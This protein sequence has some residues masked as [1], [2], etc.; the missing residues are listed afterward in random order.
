VCVLHTWE[1]VKS[2]SM[3]ASIQCVEFSA[4]YIIRQE[5]RASWQPLEFGK[6]L[7]PL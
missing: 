6:L 3:Q 2:E 4:T 7:V 5:N 1:E